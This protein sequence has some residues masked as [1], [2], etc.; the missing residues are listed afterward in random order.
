MSDKELDLHIRAVGWL[1]ILGALIFVA[2]AIFVFLF[3]AGMGAGSGELKA[4]G[5][6][7][8]IGFSTALFLCMLA[9][10]GLVV[11]WAILNRRPWARL[12]GIVVGVLE[13]KSQ[14]RRVNTR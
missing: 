4:F 13:L 10:P 9:T 11:G 7:G 6:L 8:S 12:G 1:H 3:F 14:R 5:I 2:S